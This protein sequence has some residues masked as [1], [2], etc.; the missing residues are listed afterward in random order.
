MF[1]VEDDKVN[2]MKVEDDIIKKT[3]GIWKDMKETGAEYQRRIR[4]ESEK[5]LR[6][7]YGSRRY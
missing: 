2:I 6:R 4:K 1:I 7:L 5:R 3:A